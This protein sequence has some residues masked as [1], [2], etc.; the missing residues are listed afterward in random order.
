MHGELLP[1]KAPCDSERRHHLAAS[2][3]GRTPASQAGKGGFDSP[4]GYHGPFDYQLGHDSFK[5]EKRGQHPHGL[6]KLVTEDRT[7]LTG[8]VVSIAA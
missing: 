4:R 6:P 1:R 5:V 3:I 8:F 7:P 2:S